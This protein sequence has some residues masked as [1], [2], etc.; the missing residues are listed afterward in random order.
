M[1]WQQPSK[2]PGLAARL[3]ALVQLAFP[4]AT[5]WIHSVTA[6]VLFAE[7]RNTTSRFPSLVKDHCYQGNFQIFGA[8]LAL[9]TYL[10]SRTKKTLAS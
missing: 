1:L 5:E 3:F 7:I 2:K 9:L 4:L 8:R 10:V 6:A